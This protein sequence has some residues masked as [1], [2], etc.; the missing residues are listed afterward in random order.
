MHV[1]PAND[2]N[3]NVNVKLTS[4]SASTI[5][6][7][8][9]DPRLWNTLPAELRQPDIELVHILAAAKILPICLSVSQA[10]SDFFF[11]CAI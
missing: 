6:V 7:A 5:H 3:V 1:K 8:V 9:T 10:H 2:L 4:W 11:N